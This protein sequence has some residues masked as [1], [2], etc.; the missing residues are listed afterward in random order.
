VRIVSSG[1]T[2]SLGVGEGAAGLTNGGVGI[3][4]TVFGEHAVRPV[5]IN[6]AA[7]KNW[8]TFIITA[9]EYPVR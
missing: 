8:M 4:S 1:G 2:T 9:V 5:R 7:A 3:G 6:I